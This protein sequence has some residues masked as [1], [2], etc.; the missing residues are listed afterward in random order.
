MG[1]LSAAVAQSHSL[2]KSERSTCDNEAGDVTSETDHPFGSSSNLIS[3]LT[4]AAFLLGPCEKVERFMLW[5]LEN[6]VLQTNQM[7]GS[8]VFSFHHQLW[9]FQEVFV[10]EVHA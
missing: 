7:R 9:Q 2:A 4:F 10:F 3:S 1:L 5:W 8:T 6:R